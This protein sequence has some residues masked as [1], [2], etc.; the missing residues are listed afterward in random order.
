[1]KKIILFNI[2]ILV[3]GLFSFSCKEETFNPVGDLKDKYILACVLRSDSTLQIAYVSRSYKVDGFDPYSNSTDPAV[4]GVDL[5]VWHKDTVYVF[6]DSIMAQNSPEAYS[7]PGAFYFNKKFR[8]EPGE[9]VE[10]EALMPDGKRLKAS[11][12][13]PE[14]VKGDVALTDSIVPISGKDYSSASWIAPEGSAYYVPRFSVIYF[15][16]VNGTDQRFLKPVPSAYTTKD[17]KETPVF[18]SAGTQNRASFDKAVLD[19]VMNEISE[20]DPDKS[21][22][23][24]LSI[25]VEVI[26]LD[27]NAAAYYA[28]G[29]TQADGFTLKIDQTDFTNISGGL[30]LFGAYTKSSFVMKLD[31]EYIRSFRYKPGL[32]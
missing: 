22:Y 20:G 28:S 6:R 15:K 9:K 1:M 29:K 25:Q 21:N 7:G 16:N 32:K 18:P 17:G 12:I 30:G 11:A 3:L 31:K 8:P 19:R 4:K 24:I 14:M 23:T 2:L 27:V 13:M 26:S 10:I 5:R